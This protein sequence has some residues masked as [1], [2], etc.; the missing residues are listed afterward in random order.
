MLI[1]STVIIFQVQEININDVDPDQDGIISYDDNCVFIYNP[2]QDDIDSD[3]MGD[4]C[5]LCD[6]ENIWVYGNING[7]LNTD[8]TVS[9]D[10]FDILSLSDLVL[11]TNQEGC[12]Y[13]VGDVSGDEVV[14]NIDVMRLA[15]MIM[16][17]SI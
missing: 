10:V 8:S 16:E 9:I 2:D 11:S 7:A 12:A 14:N 5:D 13:Q 15:L 3:G 6:N 4:A 17:G 1:N